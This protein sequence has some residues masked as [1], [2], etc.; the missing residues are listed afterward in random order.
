ME[1][2][3]AFSERGGCICVVDGEFFVVEGVQDSFVVAESF[4]GLWNTAIFVDDETGAAVG[5]F[6][7]RSEF[8][9]R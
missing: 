8:L 2:S 5:A 4:V 7:S 9:E 6:A 3:V 1:E